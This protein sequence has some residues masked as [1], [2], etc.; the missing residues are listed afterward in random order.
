VVLSSRCIDCG[1]CLEVCPVDA[2]DRVAT[3]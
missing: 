1:E 3:S 2:I